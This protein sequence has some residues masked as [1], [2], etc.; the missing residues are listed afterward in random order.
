MTCAV[1]FAADKNEPL[2]IVEDGKYG[3]IDHEGNVVIQP[4]FIWA[5]DFWRGLA[6]V[7]VCGRYA[8]LDSSGTLFPLRIAVEGHLEPK[9]RGDKYGFLNASGQFKISPVFE[10][11]LPFSEG[12]AAVRVGAKWGFVN[13][14]GNEVIRP[15]FEGAFYFR[16]GVA[17]VEWKGELALIDTSGNV[18]AQGFQFMDSVAD[19]RVPVTRGRTA[20]YLDLHGKVVIPLLYDEAM[21]F[22]GGLAAVEKE[23]KWGYIDRDG[24]VIIP[25]KFDE[26]GEFSSGLAP[27]RIGQKTGFID[28]SGK[29]SFYL[30]FRYAAGFLTG[31]EESDLFIAESD[32]SRFWVGDDKFGYVNTSGH[33]IWG[34]IAGGPDHAPIFGWSEEENARSCE[35]IP[36]GMR[37]VA[38]GLPER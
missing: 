20:G 19:G 9:R 12:L 33:V 31:D 11:A 27:A 25:L 34:P 7:Y 37:A 38:V 29:F 23:G 24:K 5:N 3:F 10:E 8:S 35:G 15:Q 14:A 36:D 22:S 6:T 30:P 2:V 18:L 26:A 17:T 13:T 32:V 1:G 4:Q 28:K 21:P 16:E